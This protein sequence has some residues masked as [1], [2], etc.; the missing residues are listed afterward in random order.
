MY[1]TKIKGVVIRDDELELELEQQC[2]I[3]MVFPSI[4][5]LKSNTKPN[6]KG[7]D[8]GVRRVMYSI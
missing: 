3:R 5:E 4:I 8:E 7:R 6:T 1:E 2:F